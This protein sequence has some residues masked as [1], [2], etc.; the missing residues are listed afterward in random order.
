MTRS[1]PYS[2]KDKIELELERLVRDKVFQP[3]EYSEW[4]SPI[5]PVAKTNGSIGI[6]GD[7]KKSVNI[8]EK[9]FK[10][11]IPKTKGLQATLN[12]GKRPSKLDLSYAY[13]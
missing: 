7:Y 5:P 3:I 11:P 1:V 8:V 12:G 10:Y 9:C 6:C 13:H 4:I 2:M